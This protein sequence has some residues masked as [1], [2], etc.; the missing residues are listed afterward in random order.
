MV[1]ALSKSYKKINSSICFIIT[2]IENQTG[3]ISSRGFKPR[4]IGGSNAKITDFPY[5]ASLRLGG[6]YHLCGGSIISEKYIL[7]AAHCVDNIF[8][9]PPTTL[10]S[11][12]TGTNNSSSPGQVHKI[13]WI[14]IHPEWK[15]TQESSYRHDIAVIKVYTC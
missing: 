13:D 15:Q 10:A 6:T 8:V 5:Q 2:K 1:N 12:H 3:S 4:I 9:R 14:K 7:T 11:V